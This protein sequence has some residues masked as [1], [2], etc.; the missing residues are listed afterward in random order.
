MSGKG[1]MARLLL[2]CFA[3]G[4]LLWQPQAAARGF[5][6]GMQL[7]LGTVLPALFPF[8]VLC[9]WMMGFVGDGR[10]LRPAARF[11][12]M[13]N[14]SG[15]LAILLSWLG[16]YAVAARLAGQLRR[17]GTLSA[18]DASLVMLLGCCSSPGFVIGCIGGLLLGNL[19]LGILLYGLQLS[20]NL[21]STA[22]CL[23]LLPAVSSA[24]E[25]DSPSH[26][27]S[28]FSDAMG[29]AV[30]SS[31]QVCGC[32][33]F[34]RTVAS[35]LLPFLPGQPLVQPVL[36]GILEISAGCADFARLGGKPALYGICFCLSTLGLSVWAQ[37]S[38]LLQGGVSIKL[39]AW[40][41]AIHLVLFAL[42][43]R[44]VT[45]FLPAECAVYRTLSARVIPMH[46]IPW[47][48]AVVVFCFLC[49]A[50]YK[51]R[52]NFYNR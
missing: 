43:V 11:L 22:L 49:A 39:L 34:F 25:A 2:C 6:S 37:L 24:L 14:T 36:S 42:L 28:S 16:G 3:G 4:L 9:D 18:R 12:G 52:Q 51:V 21:L 33:L 15:V 20:A 31:L 40:N 19:P 35:A 5:E 29:R 1:K 7:C 23:P 45:P 50:L 27:Q 32:V 46:R 10:A 26:L 47:D 30:D 41:R 48:A 38:M 17:E 44:L 8:F 13:R